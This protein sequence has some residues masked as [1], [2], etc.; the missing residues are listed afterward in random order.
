MKLT[1]LCNAGLA[2]ET[3]DAMLLVDLPNTPLE[4]F[5]TL[6]EE[7]WQQILNR[8]PPYD[9]VCGFWFTHLHPDHWNREKVEEYCRRWPEIP[10]YM[11]QERIIKGKVSIGPFAIRFQRMDHAPIA[12]APPHVVTMI[13][14][15][16]G[17]VYLPADAVLDAEQH[18]CFLG[19]IQCD[20]AVWNA[21][22][23]SQPETRELMHNAAKRSF[24]YHMPA[25]K[26]DSMGLWRKLEKNLQRH[27]SELVGVVI[28]DMY[29]S[30]VII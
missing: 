27:G 17:S 26:P 21:M 22:F 6:P 8:Q 10:C 11:P 13:T 12:N 2:I 9:K 24:V 16:E 15:G 30:S 29:P 18:S 28:W 5:Y 25:Q 4:P 7:I 1:L 23:L 20:A 19:G 3:E 14:T